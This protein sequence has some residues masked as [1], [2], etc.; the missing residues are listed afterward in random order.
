MGNIFVKKPKITDVDRAILTLK[1]TRRKLAQYQN[2]LDLVIEAEKQA[3]R[4]LIR[5]KRKDRA[6]LALK[7]KK[8]QEELLKQVD[9][10]LINVE[11]Q[12]ADIELASKQKAVFESLKAGNNAMKA[13]QSEI[14]LEDVQK[15]M[16]DTAEAKA[17]QDEINAILSERLSSE[18]E[19]NV[20]A[21]FETLKTEVLLLA[22]LPHI[23]I[24]ITLESLPEVRESAG[25]K[26]G[27]FESSDKEDLEFPDVPAAPVTITNEEAVAEN[28]SNKAPL[29][30]KVLEEPLLA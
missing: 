25:P 24:F 15:L 6:L 12:L 19:E 8:T 30:S 13:I 2:Q 5:Q 11:Q 16:D 27:E 7:K 1:T 17:Y 29:K 14:N 28:I 9:S 21:E 18:D 23:Y 22:Y 10:W 3:A 20:L 4:D 26:F